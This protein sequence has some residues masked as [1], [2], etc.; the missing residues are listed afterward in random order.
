MFETVKADLLAGCEEFIHLLSILRKST[1]PKPIDGM[2][3]VVELLT[4]IAKQLNTT[5]P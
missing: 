1:H 5:H 2:S 3:T 4:S